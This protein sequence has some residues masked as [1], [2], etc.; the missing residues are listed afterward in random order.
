MVLD[1]RSRELLMYLLQ[2]PSQKSS[3]VMEVFSI[4]KRQFNYSFD[5]INEYLQDR[6]IEKIKR[7][8]RGVFIIS[9]EVYNH[10]H[11]GVK[12]S[13]NEYIYSEKERQLLIV[14]S[15]FA[16]QEELS[17]LHIS[18]IAQVSKNTILMDLKEV[19]QILIKH[20]LTIQYKRK[21]GYQI[22]GE[23]L[24]KRYL[25]I[26]TL[27]EMIQTSNA[28]R[29][30]KEICMVSH[31]DIFS[32]ANRIVLIEKSLNIRF[33]DERL[34]ELKYIV[35]LTMKRIK[36]NKV[37][38]KLPIDFYSINGTYEYEKIEF[39]LRGIKNVNEEEHIFMTMQFLI[40]NIL[41][42]SKPVL[43]EHEYIYGLV[44]EIIDNFEQIGCAKFHDKK[45]LSYFLFQ[46]FKPAY[47]RIKYNFH[48]SSDITDIVLHEYYY[49][50]EIIERAILPIEK[51]MGKKFPKSEV[52]YILIIIGGWLRKE[53]H[54]IEPDR[55]MKAIVVCNN[56]ISLS[57]YLY[58]NLKSMFKNIIFLDCIS[59]RDYHKYPQTY[60]IVFASKFIDT[61]KRLYIVKPMMTDLE[62]SQFFIKVT[63]DMLGI[64][65][66]NIT[67]DDILS[68]VDK[69]SIHMD[70]KKLRADLLEYFCQGTSSM[71]TNDM[72]TSNS[73]NLDFQQVLLE[74]H[75]MYCDK[76]CDWEDVVDL[77][78]SVL[79]MERS[80]EQGYINEIKHQI[81]ELHPYIM[82][83]DGFV[84][85]HAGI[86]D[87]VNEVAMSLIKLPK[88]ISIDGYLQADIFLMLATPDTKIHLKALNQMLDVLI[89]EKRVNK[90]R[91]A[92]DAKQMYQIIF[93]Q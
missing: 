75:V 85:L 28:E 51:K 54:L 2:H 81:K 18:D 80:I 60:D 53:N 64:S 35:L 5:K 55:I 61:D 49:L 23:E 31:K 90:L 36:Q 87:G 38:K 3:E 17:L 67:V 44:E 78:G 19:Q 8:K 79:L 63:C 91:K 93:N 47:F 46:H 82:I 71:E 27:R 21:Y 34:S 9:T 66:Q 10:F 41:N 89:K 84:I 16:R 39:L 13:N 65:S 57:N 58:M 24:D 76:V 4:S 56:G 68:I 42:M 11:E 48:I 20:N 73:R 1:N 70:E 88:K 6:Y 40:S 43:V 50:Q 52:F 86:D 62:K 74:E 15:L 59:E 29:S 25:M 69:Y 22:L 7:T 32:I 77:L 83:A 33:S 26:E 72:L 37:L 45:G 14:L 30:L 92:K 12:T